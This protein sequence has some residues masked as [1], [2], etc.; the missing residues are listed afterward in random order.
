VSRPAP[1]SRAILARFAMELRLTA[2]RGENAIAI[3]VIPA[4]VLLFFSSVP[5]LALDGD[6][7]QAIL[8]GALAIAIIA[9]GLVNLGI[10]TAYERQYGVLKRLGGS[11][12]TRGGLVVA[13]I[14]PVLVLEALQIVLLIAIA[15]G[16]LGWVPPPGTAPLLVLLA[17]ILGTAVFAGMGLLL[18]GALRA[19][20]T[21]ALANILFLAF[22]LL[23][24][25]IQPP[26]GMPGPLTAVASALPSRA[27]ADLLRGG[28]GAP[29]EPLI[30]G[31]VLVAW[32]IGV[33]VLVARTFRW[34]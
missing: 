27:L 15:V 19:E 12:L 10:S 1:I 34:E 18:A 25:V 4:A 13:K 2:R 11:P 23:G 33:L 20:A 5:L 31:V 22:L 21:L 28:L 16:V 8:P 9:T 7:V 3:I 26:A 14:A 6:R 29:G 24:G 30:A 32:S 17:V